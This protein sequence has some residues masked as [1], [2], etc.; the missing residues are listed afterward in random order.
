MLTELLENIKLPSMAV[1]EANPAFL[2]NGK[3]G[4][5]KMVPTRLSVVEVFEDCRSIRRFVIQ[6]RGHTTG[7]GTVQSVKKKGDKDKDKDNGYP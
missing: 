1:L 5:V 4:F 7:F 6:D 3:S 2:K